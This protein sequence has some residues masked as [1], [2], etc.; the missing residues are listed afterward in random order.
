MKIGVQIYK[1]QEWFGDD[2][3]GVV[4]LVRRIDELGIHQVSVVE[5][6]LMGEDL[7]AYPYGKFRAPLDYP[8]Y[9]PMTMLAAIA[10]T[11]SQIRLSSGVIISPL[12]SAPMLAKE[13]ATL[14]HLSNGRVD[15][16]VGAGWQKVEYDA[17]SIP[18]ERRF[19]RMTDQ[20]RACKVLWSQCPATYHGEF[21][22]FDRVY[23]KPFPVQAGGVPIWFGFALNDRNI[24]RIAELGD[25]WLPAERR[26]EVLA[27]QIAQ[28]KAAMVAKGRDPSRLQVR[29]GFAPTDGPESLR[30]ALDRIPEY[31]AAG[32]TVC[33][34]S[35]FEH[36]KSADQALA[37]CRTALAAAGGTAT[38]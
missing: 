34:F 36:C 28:I 18:W 37:L 14:D 8:R 10:A 19:S 33:E 12:R 30:R 29:V 4:D 11:T 21:F 32:V 27:D 1:L 16:G 38:L 17:S 5:H 15:I 31:A 3:R 2:V 9:E 24:D 35:L 20:I 23:S 13:L 22:S 6:V 26:P 25:G 7:S